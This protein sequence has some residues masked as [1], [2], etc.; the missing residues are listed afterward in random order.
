MTKTYTYDA[1]GNK[2]SEPDAYGNTTTYDY[3]VNDNLI[4]TVD[5]QG[6][7]E[8]NVYENDNGLRYWFQFKQ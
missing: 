1:H 5:A 7:E 2:Q 6:N 8:I 4:K 3:D